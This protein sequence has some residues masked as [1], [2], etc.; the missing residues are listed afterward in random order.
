LLL[1]ICE[2]R[3][4]PATHPDRMCQCRSL[5]VLGSGEKDA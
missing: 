2:P 4:S 5:K 1:Q 3:P